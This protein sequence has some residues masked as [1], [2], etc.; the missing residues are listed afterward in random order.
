MI[1]LI[2]K[3]ISSLGLCVCLSVCLSVTKS[4]KC[5]CK[6]FFQRNIKIFLFIILKPTDYAAA[7]MMWSEIGKLRLKLFSLD[8]SI[9]AVS[10]PVTAVSERI[11]STNSRFLSGAVEFDDT[12]L[13]VVNFVNVKK[14]IRFF[15]DFLLEFW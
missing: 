13:V 7:I 6:C 11:F 14:I 4:C 12:L 10:Q 2:A 1:V 9:M 15:K 3:A 8:L 5:F